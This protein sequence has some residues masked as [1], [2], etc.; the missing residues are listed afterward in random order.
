MSDMNFDG[1]PGEA[2]PAENPFFMGEHEF[3]KTLDITYH[4]SIFRLTRGKG[5]DNEKFQDIMQKLYDPDED[6]FMAIPGGAKRSQ[7]WTKE[8][9]LMIHLEYLEVYEKDDDGEEDADLMD[10]G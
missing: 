9:D 7:S 4:S 3:Y 5:G 6:H 2:S 8:G 10:Y 1:M